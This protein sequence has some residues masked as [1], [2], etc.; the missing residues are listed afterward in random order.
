MA[1]TG[2]RADAIPVGANVIEALKAERLRESVQGLSE[3]K[4]EELGGTILAGAKRQLIRSRRRQRRFHKDVNARWGDALDVLDLVRELS[5]TLGA[6]FNQRY[7]SRATEDDFRF[8]AICRLHARGCSIASEIAVL[9]RSGHAGGAHA[10]WRALHEASVVSRLLFMNDSSLAR[11]FLLHE[12]IERAKAAHFYVTYWERIGFEPVSEE[13]V[14]AVI[15]EAEILKAQFGREFGSQY[16]WAAEFLGK[17][18]PGFADLEAAAD[19]A[20]WR[21]HYHMASWGTHVGPKS[22]LWA[23]GCGQQVGFLFAGASNAGLADPGHQCLVTLCDLTEN[24][25]LVDPQPEEAVGLWL[26]RYLSENAGEAFIQAHREVEEE[27]ITLEDHT[28]EPYI[29]SIIFE[30]D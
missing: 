9:L 27:P 26:M 15:E 20:H 21:P 8:D 17:K 29:R 16:G 11:R 19:L 22:A 12:T 30:R 25:L 2:D 14:R 28:G 3:Q 23:L 10:R 18:S 24:L 6:E 4:L 13:D 5:L 7:R 1:N